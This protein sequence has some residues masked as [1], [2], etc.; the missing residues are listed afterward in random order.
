MG[1]SERLAPGPLPQPRLRRRLLRRR[2]RRGRGPR[3]EPRAGLHGLGQPRHPGEVRPRPRGAGGLLGGGPAAD[4]QPAADAGRRPGGDAAQG[5]ALGLGPDAARVRRGGPAGLVGPLRRRGARRARAGGGEPGLRE[6][7]PQGR[8]GHIPRVRLRAGRGE[9]RGG[10]LPGPRLGGRRHV[11][12]PGRPQVGA[13]A[14]R[15]PARDGRALLVLR[16]G[17]GRLRGRQRE[18]RPGVGAAGRAGVALEVLSGAQ[19]A[20]QALLRGQ[21]ALSVD[22]AEV[23]E[24]R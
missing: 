12:V 23:R 6:P 19:E 14:A 5:E 18:A 2:G 17:G 21:L 13:A 8:R 24:G 3:R 22:R 10:R 11:P 7:R 4:G 1:A 16:R 15:A 9:A 20:V